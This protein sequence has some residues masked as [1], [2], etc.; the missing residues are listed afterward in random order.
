MCASCLLGASGQRRGA[1]AWA[2]CTAAKGQRFACRWLPPHRA[3]P[4]HPPVHP[5][6]P[7]AAPPTRAAAGP[8]HPLCSQLRR[9]LV[10]AHPRVHPRAPGVWFG[11]SGPG[12]LRRWVAGWAGVPAWAWETRSSGWQPGGCFA[13]AAAA[14]ARDAGCPHT[15]SSPHPAPIK[16]CTAGEVKVD[17]AAAQLECSMILKWCA[18]GLWGC[19]GLAGTRR[20]RAAGGAGGLARAQRCPAAIQRSYS[21][22]PHPN[23][24]LT[25]TPSPPPSQAGTAATLA[26]SGSCWSLL[27]RTCRQVG[28]PARRA[29]TLSRLLHC[30]GRASTAAW[31][32]VSSR[33]S[34][35]A[36]PAR[37]FG[38][39]ECGAPAPTHPRAGPAADLREL[40]ATRAVED[41]ALTFRPYDWS[42]NSK[43]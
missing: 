21:S 13:R 5:L 38:T 27:R 8:P 41:I 32:V 19:R 31:D 29:P 25:H 9:R 42:T 18:A 10:P 12:L 35:A 11:G 33:G 14:L 36:R 34:A 37:P 7:P 3:V 28:V 39:D 30:G 4:T 43:E 22:L 1:W 6:V 17:K 20:R 2:A 15:P 16:S 40:L 23:L 26:A 24:N